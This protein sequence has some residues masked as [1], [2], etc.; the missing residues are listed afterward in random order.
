MVTEFDP[1][2]DQ[3]YSRGSKDEMFRVVAIDGDTIEIQRFDGSIEEL[4]LDAWRALDV[5]LAEA[6]EDWTGPF[7]NIEADDVDDAQSAM[8]DG[9]RPAQLEPGFRDKERWQEP[10]PTVEF[11]EQEDVGAAEPQSDGL[12]DRR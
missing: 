8:P 2:I 11:E 12:L 4:D 1:S 10:S 7:D 6:P 5:E 3:W 9:Q